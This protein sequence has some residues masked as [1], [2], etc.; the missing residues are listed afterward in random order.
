MDRSEYYRELA[1]FKVRRRKRRIYAG[2]DIAA[3]FAF[4]LI[5]GV[6]GSS[7]LYVL[8]PSAILVLGLL[9]LLYLAVMLGAMQESKVAHWWSAIASGAWDLLSIAFVLSGLVGNWNPLPIIS[10]ILWLRRERPPKRPDA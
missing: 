4:N 10:V 1:E 9:R 6:I 8:D 3:F 2:V 5:K 7:L